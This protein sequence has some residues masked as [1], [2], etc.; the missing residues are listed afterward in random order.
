MLP[1]AKPRDVCTL[2]GSKESDLAG[3]T[4]G[5]PWRRCRSCGAAFNG[6]QLTP[7]QVIEFYKDSGKLINYADTYTDEDVQQYRLNHVS[8]PTL[9]YVQ[10]VTKRRSGSWLDIGAGNGGLLMLAKEAGFS[11]YGVEISP[12]LVEYGKERY[13]IE[14]Y[15][16]KIEDYAKTPNNKQWDIISVL[17]VTDIIVNPTEY[18]EICV[19]MLSDD[20]VLVISFPNFDSLSRRVQFTYP[21]QIVCR[22]LYP[23]V[24]TSYTEGAARKALEKAGLETTHVWYFG[25]DFYELINNLRYADKRFDGSKV[26]L[27][28]RETCSEFQAVLDARRQSDEFMIVARKKK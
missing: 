23:T 12:D 16:G 2:C 25:M 15:C 5:W 7:E 26:D 11:V 21:D 9:D 28:L 8:R 10:E 24:I 13:G 3:H 6:K 18:F 4:Y 1:L 14:M 17:G 19:R 27:F 22:F 20:G